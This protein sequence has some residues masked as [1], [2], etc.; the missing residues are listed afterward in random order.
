MGRS[1]RLLLAVMCILGGWLSQPA[2][3]EESPRIA[4]LELKGKLPRGQLSVMS[5]KVRSGVLVAMQGKDYV[6]MSRENMA[7]LLKDMGLDCESAQGECEV[8]TGRNIG[9]AYVVSGSVEDVGDGL[10]LVSL[11]VH[12]TASGAL[13]ATG[14]VRGTKVIQLIDKL[15]GTV[16]QVMG[17]A[18]G[19]SIQ[20][21]YA[22]APINSGGPAQAQFNLNFGG[23][24]GGGLG[25]Q[26]KLKE[27]QCTQQADQRGSQARATRLADAI[28][29]AKTQA[30]QAWQAQVSELEMCTKLDRDQRSSCISAVESW[31]ATARSMRVNLPAGVETVQTD[32]GA[33]QPAYQQETRM[34]AADQV[35]MAESLLTR[36]KASSGQGGVF[37]SS[38]YSSGGTPSRQQAPGSGIS[39]ANLLNMAKVGVPSATIVVTMRNGGS[40]YS[41]DDVDCLRRGRA[42]SSVIQAAQSMPS[43]YTSQGG[44]SGGGSGPWLT[45]AE[46]KKLFPS[47]R[48]DQPNFLPTV[49]AGVMASDPR[50]AVYLLSSQRMLNS[51]NGPRICRAARQMGT[52][53]VDFDEKRLKASSQTYSADLKRMSG[54]N[55]MKMLA[56][57]KDLKSTVARFKSL[58]QMKDAKQL[59]TKVRTACAR[60]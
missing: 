44:G 43:A 10:M 45:Q 55:Q 38:G 57:I 39:C 37:G 36:L 4:V 31:L 15:P 8:E 6:V 24:G 12:D 32:C 2:L 3:A 19:T 21:N 16:A 42:P 34:V 9:A 29:Q 28:T 25:V 22:P 33:K 1:P 54:N 56:M 49:L 52:A 48:A 27:Q 11:K 18:F 23:G 30:R 51:R 17:R 50:L 47:M 58:F 14:D 46:Q 59:A 20:T 7:I 40:T 41:Q 13:K 53:T 5:D 60:Y 26:A 35:A